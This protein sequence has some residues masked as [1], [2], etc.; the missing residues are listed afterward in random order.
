MRALATPVCRH[1]SGWWPAKSDRA[2][3]SVKRLIHDR[4]GE[5]LVLAQFSLVSAL[6]IMAF[7]ALAPGKI[8]WSVLCTAFGASFLGLWTLK[9]NPPG[10]FNIRPHPKLGGRLVEVGPY[11]WIRHPMYSAVLLLGLAAA[12]SARN[13]LSAWLLYFALCLVMNAKA[14]LEERLMKLSHE[15]YAAYCQ[16][17]RRFIPRVY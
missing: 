8:S 15:G 5:A 4:A 9:V 14:G 1:W 6:G 12:L 16:K 17:R 11:R 2:P 13:S 3:M 7:Q 10:N